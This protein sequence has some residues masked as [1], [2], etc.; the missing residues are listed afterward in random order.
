MYLFLSFILTSEY[1]KMALSQFFSVQVVPIF[2]SEFLNY[3]LNMNFFLNV[4]TFRLKYKLVYIVMINKAMQ[5]L[6]NHMMNYD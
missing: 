6:F 3:I 2:D 5:F 1:H 4:K